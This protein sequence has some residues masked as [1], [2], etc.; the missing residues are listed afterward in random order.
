MSLYLVVAELSFLNRV[1]V[2]HFSF[3]SLK[4][5]TLI[6][7][8]V[9]LAACQKP[10]PVSFQEPARIEASSSQTM[11]LTDLCQKIGKNMS[12][13]DA[14]RTTFALEQINQDLKLCLPLLDFQQQKHLL[15]LSNKMYSDF[16][17][18][19]RTPQQQRAFESYALEM[20]QHP[21]IQQSLFEQLT[22]RDQ[23]LIKH[24]GQSY[25]ELFDAG[26]G[27]VHYRRSPEYLAKIFAPYL[28]VAEQAFIEHLAAQNQYPA[29]IDHQVKIDAKEIADRALY[30]E[31]YLRQYPQSSYHQDARHLLNLYSTLLFIGPNTQAVYDGYTVQSSYLEEIERLAELKNS[32]VTDHA[33]LFLKFIE[34]SPEQ[35]TAQIILP[36]ST[37][38]QRLGAEQLLQTQLAHFIQLRMVQSDQGKDCLNDAICLNR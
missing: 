9:M 11:D 25:V 32:V 4:T 33:R 8:C 6:F 14:Q 38:P 19:D 31:S 3:F 27:E 21:T 2:N 17:A 36:A 13:I 26:E 18:V 22:L 35:R 16:L 24:Q 10:E 28:P 34:L 30:W 29:V 23:Y 37:H 20:A 12:E 15:S 7:L 1:A 5:Y